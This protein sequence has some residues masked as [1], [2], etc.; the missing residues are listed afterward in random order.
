MQKNLADITCRRNV[1]ATSLSVCLISRKK[2]CGK[3]RTFKPV[4]FL[5]FNTFDPASI[6]PIYKITKNMHYFFLYISIFFSSV[7]IPFSSQLILHCGQD[8][9][10]SSPRTT[11]TPYTHV[12]PI[13]IFSISKTQLSPR[14]G[15][16]HWISSHALGNLETGRPGEAAAISLIKHPCVTVLD[17]Y[18]VHLTPIGHWRRRVAF[19]LPCSIAETE[20]HNRDKVVAIAMAYICIVHV[21]R[22]FFGSGME[23]LCN[24]QLFSKLGRAA[25]W[26]DEQVVMPSLAAL[27]TFSP[28]GATSSGYMT[29]PLP[30]AFFLLRKAA[31]SISK[32]L[33]KQIVKLNF[34]YLTAK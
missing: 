8:L 22:S 17:V 4:I 5:V 9:T 1:E 18:A 15:C 6:Y 23:I 20:T 27:R 29:C 10:Q 24:S 12:L 34:S 16:V 26:K 13:Y 14:H 11:S 3:K 19:L 21:N 2:L 25:R 33:F 7:S 31:Q 30:A 28:I 32:R